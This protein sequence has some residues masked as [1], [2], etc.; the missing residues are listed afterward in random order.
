VVGGNAVVVWAEQA[1]PSGITTLMIS[2]NPL[3]F[4]LGDWMLPAGIAPPPRPRWVSPRPCRAVAPGRP[5]GAAA[6]DMRRCGGLIFACLAWTA[7]SLYSRHAA[8][9]RSR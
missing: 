6:I 7:G 8:S 4:V 2:L 3:L 5:G 9:P 1:I